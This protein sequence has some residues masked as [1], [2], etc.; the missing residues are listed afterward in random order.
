MESQIIY[1]DITFTVEYSVDVVPE[2]IVTALIDNNIPTVL[3][4]IFCGK[5]LVDN[6]MPA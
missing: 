4:R 6:G 1:A 5:L 2:E 3:P